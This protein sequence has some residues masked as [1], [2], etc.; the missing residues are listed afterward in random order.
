[1]SEDH[2][3]S[4]G[5]DPLR[6]AHILAQIFSDNHDHP[7]TS[8]ALR[9]SFAERSPDSWYS[10]KKV[11]DG[12]SLVVLDDSTSGDNAWLLDELWRAA[13][14]GDGHST[15]PWIQG[16]VGDKWGTEA[17]WIMSSSFVAGAWIS[18]AVLSSSFQRVVIALPAAVRPH[19]S[20]AVLPLVALLCG[21]YPGTDSLVS[22]NPVWRV[23][24]AAAGHLGLTGA[25]PAHQLWSVVGATLLMLS[26]VGWLLS[27]SALV[28]VLFLL[29]NR[30]VP[31]QYNVEMVVEAWSKIALSLFLVHL[32][33]LHSVGCTCF[34]FFHRYTE[35]VFWA[36]ILAALV[37]TPIYLTA[38]V[39]FDRLIDRP[40]QVLSTKF[41][42]QLL[43][44]PTT[45]TTGSSSSSYYHSTAPG[46]SSN[47]SSQ[48][49]QPRPIVVSRTSSA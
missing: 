38:A 26:V 14:D 31:Q 45:T 29:R 18:E 11:N 15:P 3:R 33:I 28:P 48:Q 43:G 19:V 20:F 8:S 41:S 6:H 44:L 27:S 9:F 10:K 36:A 13:D 49:Q 24:S 21:T 30:L 34:L 25:G 4:I 7:R 2:T 35:E 23:M 22:T 40:A 47:E 1:L 17:P 32:P 12:E 16:A 37:S 5:V 39:L 46:S 42:Q